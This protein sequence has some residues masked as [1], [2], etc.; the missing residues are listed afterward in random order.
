MIILLN[1]SVNENYWQDLCLHGLDNLVSN[2]I[3]YSSKEQSVK[4]NIKSE[5]EQT[6]VSV[7]DKGIGISPEDEYI[8]SNL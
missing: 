4:I 7:C 1:R 8:K 6:K 2:A 5:K 3:R